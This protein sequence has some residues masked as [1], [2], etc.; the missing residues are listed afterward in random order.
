MGRIATTLAG[1]TAA[2]FVAAGVA[3]PSAQADYE[4]VRQL[5][6]PEPGPRQKAA[7]KL[8][9][10]G[11][12]RLL[13]GLVDALFFT[14][15]ENRAEVV[16]VLRALSGHRAG[17]DRYQEW[18]EVVGARNDI[19][20]LD[21]YLPFKASLFERID[22]RYRD[23]LGGAGIARIR[24]E[25]IV[26]GGVRVEGIPALEYPAKLS[27]TE[28]RHLDDRDLVLGMGSGGAFHAYPVKVL[29]W[30]E[31]VND[32]VGGEPITLSYCTLCGSAV[33]YATRR[34]DGSALTFGTSG[35]LYRANKLMIDRATGSLWSNLGGEAVLGPAAAAGERLE[36]LPVVVA[37]W[38]AWRLEHP[39]TTVMAIDPAIG[40]RHGYLYEEGAADREREGVSFPVWQR[41]E[42]LPPKAEVLA[43]RVGGRPKAYELQAVR[44]QVVVNDVLGGVAVVIVADSDG[45]VRAYQRGTRELARAAEPGL[46]ID[47]SG[48]EWRVD[49]DAL[50]PLAGDH[51]PLERL[52]SH[53]AFWFGWYGFYPDTELWPER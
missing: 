52:P 16:E 8:S 36:P 3:G 4:L 32:E 19:D 27:A 13:P 41:D 5:M 10:M 18:V 53:L 25:E 15:R 35:L 1:A 21:G 51:S 33:L 42:R 24:P 7:K 50:H 45:A 34:P 31:M 23:I 37:R 29:S 20:P 49:E 47:Q 2:L 48:E 28:A 26:W 12:A 22:P 9:R 39:T 30:H 14:P 38:G 40:R 43:L 17:G 44:R 11:D 6:A 46:L